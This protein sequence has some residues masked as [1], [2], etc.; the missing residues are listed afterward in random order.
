PGRCAAE[1]SSWW[2]RCGERSHR[3]SR[4]GAGRRRGPPAAETSTPCFAPTTVP[5]TL[6]PTPRGEPA[7]ATVLERRREKAA[8]CIHALP[9]RGG[10]QQH[11][12]RR[13]LGSP[14]RLPR[15]LEPPP[16][17]PPHPP[18]LPPPP[19]PPP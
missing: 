12:R 19:R 14:R 4:P 15:V 13:E 9:G 16:P 8:H 7:H 3:G 2:R 1:S 17:H 6:A 10:L 5:G 18:P 11:R